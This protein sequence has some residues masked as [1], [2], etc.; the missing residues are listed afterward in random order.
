MSNFKRTFGNATSPL[1]LSYLDDNFSQLEAAGTSTVTLSGAQLIGFMQSG[2]GAV[3]QTV[4]GRFQKTVFV[5]DFIPLALQDGIWANTDTTDL[6]TYIQAAID[7]LEL[8][9][10]GCLYFP[11]GTY[12]AAA[13]TAADNKRVI[14]WGSGRGSIL[15]KNANGNIINLG[16]ECG[17]S[18]IAL[19]GNGDTYTGVGVLINTGAL[20]QTSWRWM[21]HVYIE[22]TASYC[23][24]FSGNR[25][26]YAS[27][28]SHCR[29]L[30]LDFDGN[31]TIAAVKMP[32]LGS[33][34]SNGN[35]SLTDCWSASN[36]IA[37]VSDANNTNIVN[38]QGGFPT[39][40]ANSAKICLVGCRIV[41]GSGS[42]D[43]TIDGD[44]HSIIGNDISL[45]G[46]TNT[47]IFSSGLAHV[48]FQGNSLGSTT[49]VTDNAPGV[50]QGN[51]IDIRRS[52]SYTATWTASVNPAIGDGSIAGAF[53]R[54]GEN[55]FFDLKVTMGGTTTYGTGIWLFTLPYTASRDQQVT[56]IAFDAGGPYTVAGRI[57]GGTNTMRVAGVAGVL[58]QSTVPFTWASG[59]VLQV[60]GEY[61]IS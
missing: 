11:Y 12:H 2:S 26:G 23:V 17:M 48:R 58:V 45:T 18:Y 54:K 37:D 39:M 32:T 41:A 55:C 33:A 20:N 28:L 19:H 60:S 51:F 10:G 52:T 38:C 35:R 21:D 40:T 16:A 22:E 42:S 24:E 61:M 15:K 14:L 9:G 46:G 56:A 43:W 36:P 29:F 8:L 30:P 34:E 5:T 25:A 57:L 1:A 7:Y 53:Q 27:Q 4:A 31:A 13:L 3:A 49:T 59:D 44:N 47:L 50:S 6:T